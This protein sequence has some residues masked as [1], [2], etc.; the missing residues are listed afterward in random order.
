VND[1]KYIGLDIHRAMTCAAVLDGT[2]KLVL[3]YTLETKTAT[4]LQLLKRL[5]GSLHLCLEEGTR[6]AQLQ[7]QL[8]SHVTEVLVCDSPRNA[9]LKAGNKN[10]RIEA[11]QLA[12][13]WRGGLHSPVYHRVTSPNQ[14]AL[15]AWR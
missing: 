4:V 11:R 10:D 6:A 9:L 3:E 8:K 7:C 1:E 2:G 5:Y 13:Q 14:C 15:V 12:D